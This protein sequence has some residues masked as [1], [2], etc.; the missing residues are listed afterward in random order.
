MLVLLSHPEVLVEHPLPEGLDQ[1]ELDQRDLLLQVA[2]TARDQTGSPA[3]LLGAAMALD[4]GESLS[5]LLREALKPPMDADVA[6]RYWRT[7]WATCAS[8]PWSRPLKKSSAAP[9]PMRPGLAS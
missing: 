9:I 8:W 6:R 2:A 7:P 3:A 4:H 1:L 5:A